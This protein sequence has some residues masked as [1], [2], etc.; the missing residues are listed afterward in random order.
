[1]SDRSG[2][3]AFSKDR[4]LQSSSDFDCVFAQT[5]VRVSRKGIVMLAR[6]NQL[7]RSRLGMVISK[8][9]LKL[10]SDRNQL[11]RVI[12]EWFRRELR[13]RESS[14]DVI[15]M[16]R[17]GVKLTQVAQIL[18]GLQDDLLERVDRLRCA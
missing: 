5:E 12:R 16:S 8:R 4:R 10:A 17:P 11:K 3:E 15:V 18:A 2:G 9:S 7:S 6:R 13:L 1:M 14:L